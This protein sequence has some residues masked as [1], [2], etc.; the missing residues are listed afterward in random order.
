MLGYA[1]ALDPNRWFKRFCELPSVSL[2]VILT[3]VLVASTD[4]P[5]T[6]PGD[7][8]DRIIIATAR[9]FGYMLV[10]RDATILEYGSDGHVQAIEC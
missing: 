9:A 7:P 1:L 3:S 10:M 8:A 5:G 4:L 2:T 6:P